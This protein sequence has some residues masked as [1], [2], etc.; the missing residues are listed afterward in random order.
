MSLAISPAATS[1]LLVNNLRNPLAKSTGG[2]RAVFDES[3]SRKMSYFGGGRGTLRVSVSRKGRL[4]V[5][6]KDR[7]VAIWRVLEDEQGWEKLVDMDL[8]V[9][10]EGMR[11]EGRLS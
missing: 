3:F 1:D 4:L 6:R 5:C 9:S 11:M 8:R 7:G 2:K 10:L